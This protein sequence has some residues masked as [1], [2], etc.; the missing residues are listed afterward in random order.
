MPGRRSRLEVGRRMSLN[1]CY[2]HHRLFAARSCE[3]LIGEAEARPSGGHVRKLLSAMAAFGRADALASETTQPGK[4]FEKLVHMGRV[5][6][7]GL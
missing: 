7:V 4:F 1:H 3:M 2:V 5:F 6:R